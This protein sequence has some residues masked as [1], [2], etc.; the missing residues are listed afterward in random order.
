MLYYPE[1]HQRPSYSLDSPFWCAVTHFVR[2]NG[3]DLTTYIPIASRRSESR[4][5]HEI[6]AMCTCQSKMEWLPIDTHGIE[7]R[8]DE[9]A[10]SHVERNKTELN[11]KVDHVTEINIFIQRHSVAIYHSARHLIDLTTG[12]NMSSK[13]ELHTFSLNRIFNYTKMLNTTEPLLS[14]STPKVFH[15]MS[16]SNPWWFNIQTQH[17]CGNLTRAV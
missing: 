12:K 10:I 2:S 4:Y 3:Y 17:F 13:S 1:L 15:Q 5:P 7:K 8:R 9:Y 6:E 16:K 11:R 14:P